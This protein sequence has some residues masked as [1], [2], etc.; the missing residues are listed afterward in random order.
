MFT[1]VLSLPA[2]VG[3]H[4]LTS[5]SFLTLYTRAVAPQRLHTASLSFYGAE[6]SSSF[7]PSIDPCG[8]LQEEGVRK[9]CGTPFLSFHSPF[10]SRMFQETEPG[11]GGALTCNC[12]QDAAQEN[13][14]VLLVYCRATACILCVF[15]CTGPL[16]FPPS[17]I[18]VSVTRK[19]YLSCFTPTIPCT[20]RI[21]WSLI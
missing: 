5:S 6:V 8:T 12:N 14:A 4:L 7:P 9:N 13:T 17:D 11:M 15:H 16:V 1:H 3:V 21:I 10:V 19:Q 20:V 18:T 2:Y